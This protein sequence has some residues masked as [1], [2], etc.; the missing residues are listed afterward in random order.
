MPERSISKR[1][2]KCKTVKP[3]S[4]FNK[5]KTHW[6]GYR[7]E[8]RMCQHEWE[9]GY[10]GSPKGQA[11]RKR[12][13]STEHFK[14]LQRRN[15]RRYWYSQKG[16]A[17]QRR[18]DQSANGKARS[19]RATATYRRRHP[20]RVAARNAVK[21]AI[22]TMQLPQPK[23]VNC[24]CGNKADHWHH[25]LGYAPEHHLD[26]VPLCRKCHQNILIARYE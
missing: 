15:Y 12:Y 16:Q 4:E 25:H 2:S 6:D 21:K 3:L 1:C 14:A 11:G 10:R 26:V 5:A 18:Y 23:D 22:R 8:C 9:Y 24:D 7:S 17:T 13:T 20:D 19:R